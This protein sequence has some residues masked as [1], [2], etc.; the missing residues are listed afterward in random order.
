MLMRRW[1]IMKRG[2]WTPKSI[3]GLNLWVKA[4][5]ISGS[6]GM[7][8]ATW[9]DLSGKNNHLTQ[10]TSA[11]QPLLKTGIINGKPVVRFD[12]VNDY[13][14]RTFLADLPQPNTI[15][16]VVKY[17]GNFA[18]S[19]TQIY[20]QGVDTN[21]KHQLWRRNGYGNGWAMNAGGTTYQGALAG[22][23]TFNIFCTTWND[24]FTSNLID[25][26]EQNPISKSPSPGTDVLS[27]MRLGGDINPL[28]GNLN[29]DIAEVIL[30]AGNLSDELKQQTLSYLSNYYL[31]PCL[32]RESIT[33]VD[34]GTGTDW[35]GRASIKRL[36]NGNLVMCYVEGQDHYTM[37]TM[38]LHIRFSNNN[39]ESWSLADHD[40]SG[41][42]IAAFPAKPSSFSYVGPMEPW[43]ILAPNGNL[44][45]S[46]WYYVGT[47]SA[48]NAGTYQSISSDG[49]ITWSAFASVTFI[50]YNPGNGTLKETYATDDDFVYNGVIYACARTY[51][52][53]DTGTPVQTI[54]ISSS[55][56]GITWNYVSNITSY[57]DGIDNLGTQECGIEYL[58]NNTII[59]ILRATSSSI[60]SYKRISTD[61]GATWGALTDISSLIYVAGRFRVRT[62]AHLMGQ[63]NWWTDPNLI[64][65]GFVFTGAGRRNC[66][67]TSKDAGATW[68]YPLF[69]DVD[70]ND[71]GYGDMIYDANT[72]E[73]IFI[74]YQGA[75]VAPAILNSYR[76]KI[77]GF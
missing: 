51:N 23:N 21:K 9:L 50:G 6:D 74:S 63:A 4:D 48:L 15:F 12:G 16:I 3:P 39:G 29:G 53:V 72:G 56:N 62:R 1:M 38:Y 25:G 61:M 73:Y 17:S 19:S 24:V 36:A 59:A 43:L 52:Y 47:N 71:A 30:C 45:L 32:C 2:G 34:S 26:A 41:N 75:Q 18:T 33:V 67:W 28:T 35:V 5:Q 14:D 76:F 66:V 44:I 27:G 70:I 46:C 58:G 37:G 77:Y 10:A 8:V 42:A 40:L 13:L 64:M 11:Y 69:V 57:A 22:N 54:L 7:A 31:I 20:Y 55:D 65:N 60:V 49:G 68:S